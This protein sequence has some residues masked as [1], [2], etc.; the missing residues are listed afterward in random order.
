MRLLLRSF[1]NSFSRARFFNLF[2]FGGRDTRYPRRHRR[3]AWQ[4]ARRNAPTFF[5]GGS[6]RDYSALKITEVVEEEAMLR[7]A[8]AQ[9]GVDQAMSKLVEESG[10]GSAFDCHQQAHSIGRVG[11]FMLKEKAFQQCNASCHSGCYHGAMESFLNE[12]GMEN[13][14]ENI[15]AVC[16]F[17]ETRF[18]KFECLHGVG[19]GVLAYLDY[20]LPET[21]RECQALADN[22]ATVSCYGGAFM[23]NVLSGQGLGANTRGHDTEWVNN[24][25]P[26]FPC[27]KIDQNFDVQYQCY[28]MQ[29]SWMLTL[30]KY[31]FD[32]VAVECLKAPEN[33]VSVCF[34]SFGRDVAG[35]TLRNPSE[36]T[37]LCD[38]APV[39]SGYRNDCV[40]GALNVI[41]D[42]WGPELQG[43]ATELCTMLSGEQ[44]NTCY[45]TLSGRLR[46]L[47][48]TSDERAKVCATFEEEYQKLC[49]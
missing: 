23:E 36:I 22:F 42:F 43:Q 29:T 19:H 39:R 35:Q 24:T 37:R 3:Y 5:W 15:N 38:K 10:G 18:G 33:M 9:L 31:D 6:G 17:F 32:K 40:V 45:T 20:D 8:I 41:V 25:D 13:L 7:E 4:R 47:F 48:S 30:Y 11:Y 27:D 44:K 46:D 21:L 49:R 34:R 26:H 28:Q 14:A 12:K 2:F 16:K 1:L